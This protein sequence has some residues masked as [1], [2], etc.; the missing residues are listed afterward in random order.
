MTATRCASRATESP[1]GS[2]P[3]PGHLGLHHPRGVLGLLGLL[4]LALGACTESPAA[5]PPLA[6]GGGGSGAS[7]GDPPAAGS[8]GSGGASTSSACVPGE[9]EPL[10][11]RAIGFEDRVDLT[12]TAFW[13]AGVDA[14]IVFESFDVSFTE[15]ALFRIHWDGTGFGPP[16]PLSPSGERFT[17]TTT[18]SAVQLGDD[19]YLYFTGADSLAQGV[20]IRRCRFVGESCVDTQRVGPIPGVVRLQSFPRFTAA[21]GGDVLVAYH[22]ASGRPAFARSRDGVSFDPPVAIDPSPR[23]LAHVGAFAS[24]AL[25]FS[26]QTGVDPQL[27]HLRLSDDDGLSWTAPIAVTDNSS[28]VHDANFLL[29]RD[30]DL[31]VAFIYPA[32]SF[33]FSVFRRLVE[34]S[35]ALGPEERLTTA[36]AGDATKPSL[37]RLPD[38]R[39]LLVY[40]EITARLLGGNPTTHRLGAQVFAQDAPR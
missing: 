7:G 17:L 29:R 34:P 18:P 12:S 24:G 37:L 2:L 10:S 27:T 38:C 6:D 31:D 4:S 32:E 11:A 14:H 30:G 8:G 21:P 20:E 23:T 13:G 1:L 19:P 5:D 22:D 33:G 36:D 39:V 28:N 3:P 40:A 16:T 26:H 25:A 15:G 9:G 35:G